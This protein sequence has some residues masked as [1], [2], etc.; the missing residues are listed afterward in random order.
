MGVD[1]DRRHPLDGEG[2]RGHSAPQPG[3]VR[4]DPAAD[5]RVD[6]TPDAACG[7][8]GSDLGDRVHD[9]VGVRRRAGDHQHGV[10]IDRRSHGSG[11][12]PVVGPDRHED[13]LDAEVV[14]GLVERRMCRGWQHH[15]WADHVRS[16]V[17][18]A[19]DGQQDRLGAARGH[20][21]DSTVGGVEQPARKADEL[22]LHLQERGEGRRVEGVGRGVGGHRLARYPVDLGVAGVVD[23]GEGAAAVHRQV[24]RLEGHQSLD[25]VSHAGLL[26]WPPPRRSRGCT[27]AATTGWPRSGQQA[28]SR[29]RS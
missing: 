13:R 28:R 11:I 26:P 27:G 25:R 22:V 20:G 29:S 5:A 7:G 19:L 21:A 17:A 1:R 8:R 6:V 24:P 3:G 9:P 2:P 18:R 4:Q 16:A 12:G 23:V 15:P 14:R 10:V